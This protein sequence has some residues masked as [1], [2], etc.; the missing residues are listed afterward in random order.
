M[1]GATH[2]LTKGLESASERQSL[3]VLAYN[4]KR[5]MKLKGSEAM[6]AR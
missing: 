1:D 6:I 3:H 4:P 5:V 2:L